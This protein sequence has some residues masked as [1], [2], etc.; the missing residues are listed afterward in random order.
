MGSSLESPWRCVFRT[1]VF[2]EHRKFFLEKNNKKI[3]IKNSNRKEKTD[4]RSLSSSCSAMARNNLCKVMYQREFF[5]NT[6][7]ELI[8]L[9]VKEFYDKQHERLLDILDRMNSDKRR[10]S[11][12]K[13]ISMHFAICLMQNF[14]RDFDPYFIKKSKLIKIMIN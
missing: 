5:D 1:L 11:G 3:C 8:P 9:S 12:G 7:A 10:I 4:Y 2:S 14:N 6:K 13:N